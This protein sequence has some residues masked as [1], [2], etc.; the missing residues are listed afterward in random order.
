MLGINDQFSTV[1]V[2]YMGWRMREEVGMKDIGIMKDF[3]YHRVSFFIQN[4]T[5]ALKNFHKRNDMYN[6]TLVVV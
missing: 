5:K 6:F 3:A 1:G 2:M 4:I